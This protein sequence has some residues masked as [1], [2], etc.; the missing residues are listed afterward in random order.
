M[1][2]ADHAE[3]GP[4]HGRTAEIVQI[5]KEFEKAG[6]IPA[7]TSVRSEVAILH[8]FDSPWAMEWQKHNKKYEPVDEIISY[9]EP[10]RAIAQS[11]DIVSPTAP[12]AQYKLVIAPTLS[13]LSHAAAKNL[14]SYV[15][16]GGHLVLGQRSGMKDVNNA[17]Q[18]QRQPGPL[19]LLL[20]GRVE[21]YYALIDPVPVT[22]E[23]GSGE[24]RVALGGLA[25]SRSR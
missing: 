19:G 23:W 20:G 1:G 25:F 6:P 10:I 18:T 12:L 9:Y 3:G 5:G 14:I 15:E 2:G 17:L 8:S 4:W 16:N 22:G 13:V 11:V 24:S 7:G 21:Q